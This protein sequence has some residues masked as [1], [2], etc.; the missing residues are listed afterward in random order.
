MFRTENVNAVKAQYPG[1][2]NNDIC[3]W[4]SFSPFSLSALSTISLIVSIAK[5][6]GRMWQDSPD[7]AKDVYKV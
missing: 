4:F 2:G 3:M 1:V 6:L 7:E 5:I